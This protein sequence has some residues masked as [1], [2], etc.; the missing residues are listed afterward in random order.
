MEYSGLTTSLDDMVTRA[1]QLGLTASGVA[2][3]NDQNWAYSFGDAEFFAVVVVVPSEVP[4]MQGYLSI[5]AGAARGLRDD[6]DLYRKI[7][8]AG[9]ARAVPVPDM[10]VTVSSSWGISIGL[11]NQDVEII[12]EHLYYTLLHRGALARRL[13]TK[14]IQTHGGR[15]IDGREDD[16]LHLYR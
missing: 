6:F 8:L 9:D 14:L 1:A 5:S 15:L 2:P 16:A 10:T 3:R 11:L 4:S 7:A 12:G 13:G